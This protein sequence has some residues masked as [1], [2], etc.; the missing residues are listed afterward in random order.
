MN[1][2]G[3]QIHIATFSFIL[4]EF[5]MFIWQLARYFYRLRDQHRGWYIL[6]LFLL[7]L[8][9]ITTGLFPDAKINVTVPTQNMI[10]YGTAFLIASYFPFYFYKEFDLRTLRWHALFGVPLFLILPY[11]IFFVILY[12]INGNLKADFRYGII[13]PFIYSTIL[14]WVILRTIRR[15]YEENRDHNFYIE[16]LTVY[17]AVF[18]WGAM[19]VLSWFQVGQLT[20]VLCTNSGFLFITLMFFYKSARRA[21]LE[22]LQENEI[23]ILGTEP[24][25]FQANCLHYGLTRTEILIVQLLYKGL[26]NMEIANKMLISKDTVKKHIQNIFRKTVVRNR[27]ALIH[28]LQNHQY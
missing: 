16:E 8:Y 22:Y 23:T 27:S 10:A 1:V 28:K 9:N 11:L 19:S 6:L 13:I 20:K 18:P 7:L 12:S 3:T 25:L 2:F 15:H 17:C 14:L 26:S 24:E 5:C 21:K 4:L